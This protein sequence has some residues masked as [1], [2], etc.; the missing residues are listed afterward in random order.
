MENNVYP[1]VDQGSK[2][3]KKPDGGKD[4]GDLV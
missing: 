1:K 4:R 3:R 2:E